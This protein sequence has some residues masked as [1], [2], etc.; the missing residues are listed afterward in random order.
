MTPPPADRP[1]VLLI[2][3]DDLGFSD[4]GCYGSEIPTPNLDRLAA[5]GIRM[6]S[7]YTTPRCSP[8]RASLMTGRYSH[9][10]GIGVL[11]RTVGYRGSLDPAVPT[12][13]GVLA[14]Q[15]YLTSLTGKWH[16]SAD[17]SEPNE[18]WP[19]RRG[20]ED[21]YG[22]LGGGTSYFNPRAFYRNEDPIEAPADD[23]FYL[24]DALSDHALEVIDW[25]GRENRPYFLY[26]AYT[27]PH[28]PLQAPDDD[29]AVHRGRYHVGWDAARE[30]REARQAEL[31]L[32]PAPF[33]PSPRDPQEPAWS[34]TDD[35][36]WQQ[37]RMEVFAAQVTAMDRGIGRILD[38]LESRGELENT[39]VLFLSDNGAEA[40]E[41]QVGRFLSP[42]VT[43]KVTR[44]G[45]D[46]TIGNAPD[47]E[48]GPEHTFTS[49]GRP[50]ANLSNTPFRMY[51]KWVHEGGIAAPLIVSWPAG[52]ISSGEVLHSPMHV[53]DLLPTIASAVGATAPDEIAGVD[54]LDALRGGPSPERPLFWEHIGNGAVRDGRWKLTREHGSAWELYD[55]EADR[56]ELDDLST[57][58]PEIVE[59]LAARWHEWAD[60]H[61]VIPFPRLQDMYEERGLPRWQAKS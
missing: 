53:I 31:D 41:L 34:A 28:W 10:V 5:H 55:M 51:K 11:T 43:P 47:I 48:P 39:L 37:R 13:A 6:S 35:P 40:E 58:Y 33:R 25:A 4:A 24:T 57:R 49:Y 42:H 44:Q 16:L 45:D 15:G 29:I 22:I 60:A 59:S 14:E 61:G 56:A 2:L 23:A 50:W 20:F 46:V 27:A 7:F 8:T 3:A 54:V 52:G 19:T 21:F 1:N 18:T 32:F 30:A 9:D 12:L 36:D 17:V 26:L 38:D